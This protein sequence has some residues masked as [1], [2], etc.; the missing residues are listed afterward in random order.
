MKNEV[1]YKGNLIRLSVD[2]T[3]ETLKARKE[4]HDTFKVLKGKT[5]QP[6]IL[7]PGR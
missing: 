3:A 5:L 4:G 2:F 1:S 6:S 7:D